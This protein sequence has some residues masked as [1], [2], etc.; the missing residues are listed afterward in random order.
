MMGTRDPLVAIVDDDASV[1][2]AIRRLLSSIGIGADTYLSGDAFLETLSAMPS[3][4]PDCVILDI[5]MPGL[6]GLQVQ[7]RLGGSGIPV[8]LITAHDDVGVRAE[9]VASGAFGY[10]CKPF[11]DSLLIRTVQAALGTASAQQGE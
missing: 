11:D 3:Y 6:N 2:K 4:R 10:L 5:Q 7:Q 1:G 8:I 9:A